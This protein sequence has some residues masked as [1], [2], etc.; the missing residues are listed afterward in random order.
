LIQELI[1]ADA[2]L[3]NAQKVTLP[4]PNS[5]DFRCPLSTKIIK[6]MTGKRHS[7]I[8]DFIFIGTDKYIQIIF[9]GFKTDEYW[10]G[11]G[12]DECMTRPV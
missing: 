7:F 5:S 9:V 6:A 8:G 3:Q 4:S 1:R 12:T 2:E 11:T 10:F